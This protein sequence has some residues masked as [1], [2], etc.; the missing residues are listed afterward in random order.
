[1]THG[2]DYQTLREQKRFLVDVE[3]G[4]QL[5]NREIIHQ[6][7]PEITSQSFLAMAVMVARFRA[8]YLE[9][10]QML[11]AD[12]KAAETPQAISDLRAKREAYEEA[13]AA[14][15]ALRRAIEQGYVDVQ[16]DGSGGD[17]G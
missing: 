1:M 9:A 15:E 16:L 12:V 7:I 4:V 6:R 3:R 17:A 5:A 11:A 10:A 14:F 13:V 8:T 2:D